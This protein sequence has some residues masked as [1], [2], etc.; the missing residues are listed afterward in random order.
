[1]RERPHSEQY[2]YFAMG[3]TAL[4]Q[5]YECNRLEAACKRALNAMS[6]YELLLRERR[7]QRRA[8]PREPATRYYQTVGILSHPALARIVATH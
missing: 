7:R 6:C 3:I 2:F 8:R 5:R 1:M 4:A